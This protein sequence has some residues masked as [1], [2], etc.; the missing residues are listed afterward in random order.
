MLEVTPDFKRMK[1]E[2]GDKRSLRFLFRY[3]F[4][5]KNLL[6][7]LCIGLLVGSLLQLIFP[8]LTQSIVDVGIQNQD[9]GFIYLVLLAQIMLFVGR[10]SVEVFRSWILLNP[11]SGNREHFI[12]LP[13]SGL[14]RSGKYFYMNA[15][16]PIFTVEETGYMSYLSSNQ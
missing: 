1:W 2:E 11:E 10:T 8:F 13:G 4:N 14:F 16:E 5:Y 15:W 9:I 3:L 7:Q 12:K 6:V